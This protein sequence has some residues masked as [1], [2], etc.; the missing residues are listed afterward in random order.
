MLC[1]SSHQGRCSRHQQDLHHHNHHHH[2]HHHHHDYDDLLNHQTSLKCC[3]KTSHCNIHPVLIQLHHA[4]PCG[5]LLEAQ[6]KH[7]LLPDLLAL[8]RRSVTEGGLGQ[9][10]SKPGSQQDRFVV[11]FFL[12]IMG[13]GGFALQRGQ[14]MDLLICWNGCEGIICLI[15]W[16]EN[17]RTVIPFLCSG[18]T[19][20]VWYDSI[21]IGHG[22]FLRNYSIVQHRFS[23][24]N[25]DFVNQDHQEYRLALQSCETCALWISM[26]FVLLITYRS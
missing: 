4:V 11:L 24:P 1:K 19:R 18:T 12:K 6:V 10:L 13:G 14:W 26:G 7:L 23:H 9:E 20:L 16:L 8:A 21:F 3:T 2:H 17:T 22:E 15:R 5:F 25:G